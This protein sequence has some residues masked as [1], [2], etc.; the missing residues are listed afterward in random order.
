[1]NIIM[2]VI[3][4]SKYFKCYKQA[5][6]EEFSYHYLHVDR[7]YK[8]PLLTFQGSQHWGWLVFVVMYHGLGTGTMARKNE[9]PSIISVHVQHLLYICT[10]VSRDP[11]LNAS[12]TELL[13][14]TS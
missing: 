10:G 6:P 9:A 13:I 7:T 1:M 2:S 3:V 11:Q 5:S 8:W 4:C 12:L 14:S